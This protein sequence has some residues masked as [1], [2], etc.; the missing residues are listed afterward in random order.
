ME[1]RGDGFYAE[2]QEKEVETVEGPAQKSRDKGVPLRGAETP[3][4]VDKGH[5]PENNR[6]SL[7][8]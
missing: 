1:V 3:E 4:V 7:P 5:E 8:D 2:D 6:R